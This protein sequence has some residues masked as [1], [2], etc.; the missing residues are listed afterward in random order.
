MKK[1]EI[2]QEKILI[3]GTNHD[4]ENKQMM[5]ICLQLMNMKGRLC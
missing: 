4:R 5:G 1:F 3:L 2:N